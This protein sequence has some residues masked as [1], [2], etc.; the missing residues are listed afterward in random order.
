MAGRV[1]RFGVSISPELL[2]GLDRLVRKRGY[3]NRSHAIRDLIRARMV[4]EEW[5][6]GQ[7]EV[8]GTVTIVYD[9]HQSDV[10]RTLN[11]L[12]HSYRELI[13]STLHVH[14][15]ERHCLEVVV[16][17]GRPGQ[18]RE[19][20]DRLCSAKGVKHGRLVATSTGRELA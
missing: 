8:A 16:V 12:Q 14:L 1:T 5:A 15:D 9:H 19:V 10:G 2:A 17:R 18:A 20:A 4:E 6:S 13:V 3:P 7:G 11:Q